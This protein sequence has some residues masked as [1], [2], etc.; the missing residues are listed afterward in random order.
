MR[1][2]FLSPVDLSLQQ[3]SEAELH[4]VPPFT[5]ALTDASQ[6]FRWRGLRVLP[7]AVEKLFKRRKTTIDCTGGGSQVAF[8][9]SARWVL[10]FFYKFSLQKSVATGLYLMFPTWAVFPIF[11]L[12]NYDCIDSGA[13][14]GNV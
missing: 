4:F 8:S 2:C 14:R 7:F 12:C 11:H 5:I 3:Y 13:M 6:K 10:T 9:I 1:G